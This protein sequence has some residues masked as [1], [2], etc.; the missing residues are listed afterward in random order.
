[1]PL[2]G[3]ITRLQRTIDRT[4]EETQLFRAWLNYVSSVRNTIRNSLRQY[5]LLQQNLARR[6]QIEAEVIVY[7]QL[8]ENPVVAG[9]NGDRAQVQNQ[10][11]DYQSDLAG[12]EGQIENN[13]ISLVDEIGLDFIGLDQV[14]NLE[15]AADDLYGEAYLDRP[16]ED[17]VAEAFDNDVEIQ[18]LRIRRS[19]EELKLQL[20][21]RGKWD[22]TGRVS[23]SYDFRTRGDDVRER[24]GYNVGLGVTVKR[25]D[26]QLLDLSVRQ[27]QAGIGQLDAQ[28]ENRSREISSNIRQ[29]LNQ[30]LSTRRVI[31]ESVVSVASREEVYQQQLAEYIEGGQTIENVIQARNQYFNALRGLTQSITQFYNIALGLDQSSGQYFVQLE[32]LM[33]DFESISGSRADESLFDN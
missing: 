24:S 14:E 9:R 18:V 20:A 1:M 12:L 25:N 2:I 22:I 7:Q 17:V 13:R 26:P 33:P 27:S 32:D 31:Q 11:Q 16:V 4:F 23:G 6:E 19:N 15:F 8:A 3:S 21:E 10:I 29:S 30:A 5:M 28:I